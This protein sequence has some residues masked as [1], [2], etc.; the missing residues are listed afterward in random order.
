GL[1]TGAEQAA[2]RADLSARRQATSA[3]DV[4]AQIFPADIARFDGLLADLDAGGPTAAAARQVVTSLG[5][6]TEDGFRTLIDMLDQPPALAAPAE[7]NTF[8][9]I[10]TSAVLIGWLAH[11]EQDADRL[12]LRIASRLA[13]L[14]V[15]VSAWRRL[16]AIRGSA[17]ADGPL[18]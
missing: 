16:L 15:G 7:W 6:T 11:A 17:A 12:G 13:P 14:R 1:W 8:D 10:L 5:F 9:E 3:R 4:V 18:L 2:V